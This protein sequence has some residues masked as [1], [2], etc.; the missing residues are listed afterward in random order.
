MQHL[1][2]S[3]A[4]KFGA[5]ELEYIHVNTTQNIPLFQQISY[6]FLRFNQTK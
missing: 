4:F 3:Q 6:A 1:I 2:C 5:H